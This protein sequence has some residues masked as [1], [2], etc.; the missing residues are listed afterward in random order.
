MELSTYFRINAM[1]TGQFERTLVVAEEGS[2]VELSRGLH[3]PMR[4]ENQLMLQLLSWLRWM[5]RKLSIQLCK[6]GIPVMKMASA[7]SITSS[8]SVV[9][10]AVSVQRL[11][12]R[13]LRLGQR[14][15]GSTQL[16]SPRRR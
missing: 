8:Q 13:K 15:P 14:L 10:V 2:Y 11:A 7:G 1:N 4:D 9:P 3:C 6:I 16:Y 5:M 12:G